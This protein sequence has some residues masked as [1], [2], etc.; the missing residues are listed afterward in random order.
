MR[1]LLDLWERLSS[2]MEQ[3]GSVMWAVF[4][5]TLLMWTIM[6]ERMIYM[7]WVYPKSASDAVN[8]WHRRID[9]SSW[10]AMH[11]RRK[12]ISQN[13]QGLEQSLAFMRTL[14]GLCTLLGLFGTVTGMVEV[15]DIMSIA[16]N[17][18]PRAMASGVSRATVPTMAGMVAAI[19]GLYLSTTLT[20][21]AASE[22]ELFEDHMTRERVAR[23]A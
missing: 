23:G 9:Q 6:I 15:F 17:G 13:K 18:N 8:K 14:V 2:F 7:Y 19:S 12:I 16:G 10:R 20:R 4:A 21:K 1:L 11:I 22:A 5:A 3:G